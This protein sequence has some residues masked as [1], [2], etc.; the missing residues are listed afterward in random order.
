MYDSCAEATCCWAWVSDC[1]SLS[2]PDVCCCC[3]WVSE[4]TF[5][6]VTDEVSWSTLDWSAVTFL[7]LLALSAFKVAVSVA[8]V[9]LAVVRAVCAGG[10]GCR[11]VARVDGVALHLEVEA[12][13]G[14]R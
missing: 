5:A 6:W 4:L 10:H 11:E 9:A 3:A 8:S 13:L 7:G 14:Q 12:V 1:E 2:A